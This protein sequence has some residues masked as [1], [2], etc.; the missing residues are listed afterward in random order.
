MGLVL[1]DSIPMKD[2]TVGNCTWATSKA[3]V[4]ASFYCVIREKLYAKNP[5][6]S[7]EALDELNEKP[8]CF[9]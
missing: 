4:L 6:A 2:Q 5:D 9:S 8:S 3:L 7:P 1:V